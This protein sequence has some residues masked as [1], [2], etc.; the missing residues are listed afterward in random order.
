M[1]LLTSLLIAAAAPVAPPPAAAGHI[2]VDRLVVEADIASMRAMLSRRSLSCHD[3]VAAYLRR[4][5]VL[6]QPTGLHAITTVAPDALDQADVA[7]VRAA[8]GGPLPPLHCVP[9]VA[10]DNMDVAGLPTTAGS[11]ALAGNVPPRDAPLIATL[12]AAG[13]IVI[14]KTN[15][16][17]WAFSPRR[18]ISS[19]AGETA[20][21]YALDRVP[22][23]SSGGTASAVAASLALAGLGTDT[24]NSIRGPSSHLALVG[25]RPT[26]GLVSIAG[27]VPLLADHDAAGPMT[28]TVADNA[29]LLTVIAS[30]GGTGRQ[31]DYVRALT[32]HPLRGARLGVVR[33]IA[34]TKD[35]DPEVLR[36]FAAALDE[37]RAAGATVI[38]VPLPEL[39]A[40]LKADTYCPRFRHDVNAYLATLGSSRPVADVADVYRAG[41]YA[42]P[43]AEQF[44]F[45]IKGG[46]IEGAACPT[47]EQNGERQRFRADIVAAMDRAGVAALLYP[48]WRYPPAL[49][50]RGSEDYR[51]DNSQLIA[52]V[53]GLPALTVPMGVTRG[54]L[55]AGLQWLG[56]PYAEATLYGLAFD[57]TRRFPHRAAPPAFPALPAEPEG[58]AR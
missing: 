3:L 40:H 25:M 4:I 39:A 38:D 13:A 2:L 54:V 46:P 16:A 11:V 42:P 52:P 26:L 19:T 36:V 41:R 29:R 27:I 9:L 31:E 51:G 5:R 44:V 56:R 24:G 55:P 12:K 50:S 57:Y 1:P 22:A 48:T 58:K 47:F 53:T 20:N 6:D 10:K 37:L 14:A 15:M 21:A 17:E 43:S 32:R 23:G 33:A 30:T 7:D 35:S 18:T 28:R 45:F 34:E 8:H 49:R